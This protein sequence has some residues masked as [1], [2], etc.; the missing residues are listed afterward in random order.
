MK[1]LLCGEGFSEV[2]GRGDTSGRRGGN[3]KAAS[4]TRLGGVHL[5][6]DLLFDRA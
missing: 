5:P 4:V 6:V 3:K 2:N 1:L